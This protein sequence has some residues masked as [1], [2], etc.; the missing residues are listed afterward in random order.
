MQSISIPQPSLF[1]M[2][3]SCSLFPLFVNVPVVHSSTYPLYLMSMLVLKEFKSEKDSHSHVHFYLT[4][5]YCKDT[6]G[7][8]T[9]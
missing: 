1:S 2:V 6:L 7:L 9:V 4:E 8:H 3:N 5:K